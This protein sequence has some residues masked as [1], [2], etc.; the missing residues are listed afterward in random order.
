MSGASFFAI[1]NYQKVGEIKIEKSFAHK[2]MTP[3]I[4]LRE[5]SLEEVSEVRIVN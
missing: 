4:K 3:P 2:E 1:T 5:V